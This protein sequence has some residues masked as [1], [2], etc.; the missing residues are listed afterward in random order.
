MEDYKVRAQNIE[1]RL[2]ELLDLVMQDEFA[3][4][5]K[6]D[7]EKLRRELESRLTTL[8]TDMRQLTELG[9]KSFFPGNPVF[10]DQ[11]RVLIHDIEATGVALEFRINPQLEEIALSLRAKAQEVPNLDG[12]KRGLLQRAVETVDRAIGLVAEP[13]VK[14]AALVTA[15]KTLITFFQSLS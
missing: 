14:A 1:T 2:A 6:G 12:G 3:E 15:L 13:L 10:E 5:Y 11:Q 9:K 4:V 7:V 8:R